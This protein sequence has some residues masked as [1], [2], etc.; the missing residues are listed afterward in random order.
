MSI[1]EELHKDE[2][3]TVVEL[4]DLVWI[5]QDGELVVYINQYSA[6][7]YFNTI[8]NYDIIPLL[9]KAISKYIKRYS[10]S[11]SFINDSQLVRANN[12]VD[13]DKVIIVNKIRLNDNDTMYPVEYYMVDD[14]V[15]YRDA[16]DS[17]VI[18]YDDELKY[19]LTLM[20]EMC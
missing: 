3:L 15:Y 11:N 5:Y 18:V 9:S 16:Y 6:E 1:K 4:D 8:N 14:I 10:K 7:L 2:S 19:L 13:D 12:I 20:F 17:D